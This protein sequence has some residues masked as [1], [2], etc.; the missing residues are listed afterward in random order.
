MQS[1]LYEVGWKFLDLVIP[2]RCGGCKRW[3]TRWC[4]SCQ[5]QLQIIGEDSCPKCGDP[6]WDGSG[7]MCGRCCSTK[8]YY[9]RLSSWVSFKGPIREAV[10]ELKYRHNVGLGEK[11]AKNMV[12]LFESLRWDVDFIIPVPLG[13]KRFQE[14]GYNQVLLL[15]R[16]LAWNLDIPLKRQALS[17]VRETRS[18]VGLSREERIVNVQNAFDA[19]KQVVYG[20]RILLMDDVVTTGATINA[21]A[22]AL[23]EAGAEKVFSITLARAV[24]PNSAETL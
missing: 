13:S 8:L 9:E 22:K 17:R 3:G 10:H 4:E 23:R 21:C 5:D 11:L 15:A 24:N 18:Q 14:R 2:P 6:N 16:P 20:K 12:D 19:K 7:I 1:R